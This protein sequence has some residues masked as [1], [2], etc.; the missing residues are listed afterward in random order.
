LNEG[1]N[2][3]LRQLLLRYPFT[4]FQYYIYVDEDLV[5]ATDPQI[6]S[7]CNDAAAAD[8]AAD[9]AHA[10]EHTSSIASSVGFAFVCSLRYFERILLQYEAQNTNAT[11]F[12]CTTAHA[13][14]HRHSLT[15]TIPQ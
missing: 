13:R 12:T 11:T 10:A 1:R 9:A 8:A 4:V 3:L 6:S 7:E 5:L 2:E 14:L 15:V